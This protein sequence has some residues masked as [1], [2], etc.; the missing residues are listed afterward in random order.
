MSGFLEDRVMD[1]LAQMYNEQADQNA[2]LKADVAMQDTPPAGAGV[3][4]AGSTMDETYSPPPTKPKYTEDQLTM[5]PDWIEV[6]KRMYRVMEGY[7]FIGSDKQAAAYGL[8]L[9]SEFNWNVT[10]PA[11]FPGDA[12][13]SSPGMIGQVWN[14]VNSGGY[15]D[16]DGNLVTRENNANDFLFMLNTYA[17]TKTEGATIKRSLRALFGAPE[18]YGSIGGGLAAPFI[19][20][21]AMKTS[22]MTARQMLMLTAK[23]AGYTTQ[24][25]KRKPATSG[26]I[27]GAAYAD[28]YEGGQMILES[29]AGAPPTLQEAV[30][31]ALVTTAAGAGIGGTLGKLLG[32]TVEEAGPAVREAAVSAG[33]AAEARMEQRGPLANRVMSGVDPM[34][35]VDPA[36]AAIGKMAKGGEAHPNRI[37]TRLPTAVRATED[38]VTEP[39]QIGLSESKADPKQF[40]HNV[41]I[42][43]KYP[44]MT[45]AQS[46]L[47]P[48]EGSEAFIEHVKDNL[49]WIHDKI[50]AETRERSKLWYDGARAITDRWSEQYGLP[51]ASVAGVLAALSPQMDWYKNVSLA[52]RVITT[53]AKTDV[54]ASE[55][56][57]A[58]AKKVDP[59][60]GKPKLAEKFQPIVDDMLGKTLDDLDTPLKK[61]IFVRLYDEVNNP[62]TH[63]VI[64]PEGDTMGIV[65]KADGSDAGT[66]WGSFVEI[67]KAVE[68]IESGGDKAILTPLMGTQHKVRSFYNNILDPNG[69]NGDVTIDTHAVAAG[70]LKPL[71]GQATEV[72]HN[73]GSSPSKAKQGADWTGATKNSSVTG[74]QGNYGLYAEAYRRAAAERGI[75]P[76]E[77]QSITWEAARGLFTDVYKGQKKDGVMIN[78]KAIDDLWQSYRKGAMTIDEVRDAIEQ[79]AG[80]INPPTWKE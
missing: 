73:F 37:A 12:G 78:V 14:I 49:L 65:K 5:M 21:A 28:L 26:A 25:A 51:D 39:L 47:S 36:L 62:R 79:H 11:G 63:N 41:G 46:K 34:E 15:T 42:V 69:P 40:E 76:R 68:A 29:A 24:L 4:M 66:G 54:P 60:T 75:L 3:A 55:E 19:K 44:N 35:V 72:H 33:E 20:G 52:E 9:V 23:T 2:F 30:T 64:S 32:S 58:F 1:E 80:G 74:V 13:I 77:M 22:N 50:P 57:I 8:D 18:T 38:P 59:K 27:A 10:G 6:S 45:E 48:E 7:E 56:M 71:S 31:R 43:Q 61:A 17:D 16:L 70:L 67:T 53:M